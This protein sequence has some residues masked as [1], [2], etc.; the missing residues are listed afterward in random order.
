[1]INAKR[2]LSEKI[3]SFVILFMWLGLYVGFFSGVAWLIG[4]IPNIDINYFIPMGIGVFFYLFHLLFIV[5]AY[6]RMKRVQ[7]EFLKD[8]FFK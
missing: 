2:S 5:T 8:D 6:M 4:L 3:L 1:M 7:D